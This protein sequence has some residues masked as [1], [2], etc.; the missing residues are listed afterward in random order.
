MMD[1]PKTPIFYSGHIR[2]EPRPPKTSEEKTEEPMD[3]DNRGGK[4]IGGHKKQKPQLLP[5]TPPATTVTPSAAEETTGKNAKE[6][7][8]YVTEIYFK[9]AYRL[10]GIHIV[11]NG[12]TP[13]GV[14]IQ[15]RTKP[16]LQKSF[17]FILYGR[18]AVTTEI[19]ELLILVVRGGVQ[20]MPIAPPYDGLHLAIDYLAIDGDFEEV[21]LLLHGQEDLELSQ[22]LARN[23][24]QLPPYPRHLDYTLIPKQDIVQFKEKLKQDQIQWHQHPE[25]L[26]LQQRD[27][28]DKKWLWAHTY[29]EELKFQE[30]FQE[31]TQSA[32]DYQDEKTSEQS[33]QLQALLGRQS[34]RHESALISLQVLADLVE[35]VFSL[36][37]SDVTSMREL[38]MTM[39]QLENL[40]ETLATCWKTSVSNQ[41]PLF[42]SLEKRGII[43]NMIGE[44]GAMMV[45][46]G[47]VKLLRDVFDYEEMSTQAIWIRSLTEIDRQEVTKR[48]EPAILRCVK[49]L[50]VSV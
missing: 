12:H 3:A 36:N 40:N 41:A 30:Y 21:T 25:T 16:D 46:E 5:S 14:T 42:M 13:P 39:K 47:I 7:K 8:A 22:E 31:I 23:P 17:T 19:V 9:K 29:G 50:L 44:D 6:Q 18:D 33:Q 32:G 45:S 28:K 27:E 20:W 2:K 11:P 49:L 34:I 26:K 4:Q 37:T 15:G 48:L 43:R 38:E 1:Q 24:Y 10:E 35:H